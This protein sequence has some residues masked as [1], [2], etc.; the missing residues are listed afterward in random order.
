MRDE[1]LDAA[2]S[3]IVSQGCFSRSCI[4]LHARAGMQNVVIC[5]HVAS[6]MSSSLSKC[7]RG[8]YATS[9]TRI[10]KRSTRSTECFWRCYE[11][12]G[13]ALEYA[14]G[15]ASKSPLLLSTQLHHTPRPTSGE[16]QSVPVKSVGCNGRNPYHPW[17]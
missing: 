13:V 4:M 15:T 8:L 2:S 9:T 11:T 10:S 16:S 3:S 6:I 17:I 5:S 7:K 12:N 1:G 14:K